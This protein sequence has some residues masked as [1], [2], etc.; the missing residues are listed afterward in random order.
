MYHISSQH[1]ATYMYVPF[2]QMKIKWFHGVRRMNRCSYFLCIQLNVS[3]FGW[4]VSLSNI[5]VCV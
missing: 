1:V 2:R 3:L 5:T 4:Y